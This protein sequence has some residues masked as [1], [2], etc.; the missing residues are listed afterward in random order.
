MNFNE[1]KPRSWIPAS[2]FPDDQA[3]FNY[4]INVTKQFADIPLGFLSND[5]FS[6]EVLSESE[7][8]SQSSDDN[9]I[10]EI[11]GIDEIFETNLNEKSSQLFIP[12]DNIKKDFSK[13][14]QCDSPAPSLEE[15]KN[16]F[17][18]LQYYNDTPIIPVN[19]QSQNDST[20]LINTPQFSDFE[21]D[22]LLQVILPTYSIEKQIY[23]ESKEIFPKEDLKYAEIAQSV[24]KRYDSQLEKAGEIVKKRTDFILKQQTQAKITTKESIENQIS[25]SSLSLNPSNNKSTNIL[26]RDKQNSENIN[27]RIERCFK[28]DET[29]FFV[30]STKSKRGKNFDTEL[31]NNESDIICIPENIMKKRFPN[32]LLDYYEKCIVFNS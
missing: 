14:I 11:P 18:L 7:S 20:E 13:N 23:K 9:Y 26:L 29:L 30:V 25:S 5:G 16:P 21:K 28:I 31:K 22:D 10:E 24:S 17:I 15:Q 32:A 27:V 12:E 19:V 2:D 8:K 6:I 1:I 3:A 4:W